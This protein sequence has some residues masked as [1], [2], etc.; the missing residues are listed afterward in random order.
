MCTVNCNVISSPPF[1]EL[2]FSIITINVPR[3]FSPFERPK[4]R[5]ILPPNDVRRRLTTPD[6]LR[7]RVHLAVTHAVLLAIKNS[8]VEISIRKK[9]KRL[10]ARKKK[11]GAASKVS[12]GPS[13][14]L[15]Y[16][17]SSG[18]S[19]TDGTA[20]AEERGGNDGGGACTRR[21]CATPEAG[22]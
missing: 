6:A 10:A 21:Q 17:G 15:K 12:P 11:L 3:S 22:H 5:S 7:G 18:C 8:R 4:Y 16:H 19:K 1:F 9:A 13:E 20:Q 2:L 14:F